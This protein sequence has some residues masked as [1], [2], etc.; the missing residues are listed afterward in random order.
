MVLV[1]EK[2]YNYW[3][4][5]I[6][7]C[8]ERCRRV[9]LEPA[10]E[11]CKLQSKTF[12]EDMKGVEMFWIALSQ[13]NP[14]SLWHFRRNLLPWLSKFCQCFQLAELSKDVSGFVDACWYLLSYSLTSNLISYGSGLFILLSLLLHW[15]LEP[16]LQSRR[17][18]ILTLAPR[19]GGLPGAR[20]DGTFPTIPKSGR[21]LWQFAYCSVDLEQ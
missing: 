20:W 8:N 3:W 18:W 19:G 7:T 5:I 14:Y 11:T 10:V 16:A 13:Q 17:G 15:I 1:P 9:I 2:L 6:I 12:V 21:C 4:W